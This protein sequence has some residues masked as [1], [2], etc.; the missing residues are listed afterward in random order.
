[1]CSWF[2][3]LSILCAAF[4]PTFTAATPAM[5]VPDSSTPLHLVWTNPKMERDPWIMGKYKESEEKVRA[6]GVAQE[7]VETLSQSKTRYRLFFWTVNE[8]RRE[9]PGLVPF[10]SQVSVASWVHDVLRYHI[11]L[12][13]G[14]VF[15]D[16]DVRAVHDFTELMGKFNSSFT[17]C[18]KPWSAPAPD[19]GIRE[20][21]SCESVITAIIAAPPNHPALKCAA[22]KSLEYTT[23]EVLIKSKENGGPV[24]DA[25]KTGSILWSECVRKHGLIS[26]LPSWT[27]LAC[28]SDSC[29]RTNYLQYTNVYGV[30]Y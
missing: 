17:V 25:D 14:G 1:M 16:T 29:D 18:Q 5:I 6:R 9:F 12:R 3:A 21:S 7:W 11:M 2:Y 4:T 19:A 26:V 23:Y 20:T 22:L 30:K 15:L 8:I 10:L 24:F 28:D 13:Y 27:F